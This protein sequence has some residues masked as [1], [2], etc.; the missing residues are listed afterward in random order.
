LRVPR[1]ILGRLTVWYACSSFALILVSTAAL[2]SALVANLD[3]EDV[4]FTADIVDIVRAFLRDRPQDMDG[5]KRTVEWEWARRRYAQ[6]YVRI[7]DPGGHPVVETPGMPKELDSQLFPRPV[8]I[9]VEPGPGIELAL[10][11]KAFRAV[12]AMGAVGGDPSEPRVIQ[13]A[14]DLAHEDVLLD[15]Y[16]RRLWIVLS[17]ALIACTLV[18]WAIARRGVR[19]LADITRTALRVRSSTL[20]QRI[21]TAGLPSELSALAETFNGM[22]ARLED[23]FGR[24]SR[25]SADVAHEL[26]TPVNNARGEAEVMLREARTPEEYRRALESL[27]EESVRLSRMIDSLLF[28]ARADN[29]ETQISREP[30]NLAH[31]LRLVREFYEALAAEGGITLTVEAADDLWAELDRTL[32]QRAMG[33][34]VANAL[35]H[36]PEG[37]RTIVRASCHSETLCIEVADT[38][39][40]IPAEHLP[41]V[42]DR[43]YSV[44]APRSDRS[45]RIGLGLAL[46][47][48]IVALHGGSVDIASV[49]GRGTT[50]TLRIPVPAAESAVLRS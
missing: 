37:G 34:L 1:S 22:L 50:V 47:K 44:E 28:V 15:E 23:S 12:S 10:P 49:V 30:L 35:S 42:F 38:G 39:C 20:D 19:P 27:L 41:H 43:F 36:T 21:E 24:L 29:P 40:G 18:G 45:G 13:V 5:L 2:Y 8:P 31:E 7:L 3:R 26:R 25:F 14:L 4:D 17:V 11:Q 32:L 46:V 6:V 33:N 9:D 16:R 48:S